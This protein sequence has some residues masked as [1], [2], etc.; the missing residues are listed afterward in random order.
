M[1]ATLNRKAYGEIFNITNPLTSI[2]EKELAETIIKALNSKSKIEIVERLPFKAVT[3]ITKARK[4]LGFKLKKGKD[5]FMKT[6]KQYL[7][8]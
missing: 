8:N 1:Q 3:D 5:H 4:L 2:S 6:L 7:S